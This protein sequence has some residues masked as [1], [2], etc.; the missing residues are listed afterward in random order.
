MDPMGHDY[1]MRIIFNNH[2]RWVICETSEFWSAFFP[3]DHD[4]DDDDDEYESTGLCLGEMPT[5]VVPLTPALAMLR[6]MENMGRIVLVYIIE[7]VHISKIHVFSYNLYEFLQCM[8]N[9]VYESVG[10]LQI[11]GLNIMKIWNIYLDI[12]SLL[13]KSLKNPSIYTYYLCRYF[14]TQKT[15][16][17][18]TLGLRTRYPRSTKHKTSSLVPLMALNL[19][20]T[21]SPVEVAN[22]WSHSLQGCKNIPGGC[23][24]FLNHQRY[25]HKFHMALIE[26]HIRKKMNEWHIDDIGIAMHRWCHRWQESTYCFASTLEPL[27]VP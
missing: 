27:P 14:D 17:V 26:N 3:Q 10:H 6:M 11:W 15:W 16:S 21:V 23:L 9:S 19:T 25:G 5:A 4:D 2:P 8:Y 1:S 12:Y 22:R 20:S 13:Q 24:G 7:L 18:E